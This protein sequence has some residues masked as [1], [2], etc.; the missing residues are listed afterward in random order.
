MR[1]YYIIRGTE[2]MVLRGDQMR[3]PS[4]PFNANPANGDPLTPWYETKNHYDEH[5]IHVRASSE[6]EAGK[7]G[8]NLISRNS[9]C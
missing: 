7:I 3:V 8:R 1:W 9:D 4:R 6:K 5:H 2:F